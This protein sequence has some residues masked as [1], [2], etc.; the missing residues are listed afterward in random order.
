MVGVHLRCQREVAHKN[1]LGPFER[2][3]DDLS[4][5][6]DHTG[7]AMA[8][9]ALVFP[10]DV[11]RDDPAAGVHRSLPKILQA[12]IPPGDRYIGR[13]QVIEWIAQEPSPL[14]A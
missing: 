9:L 6:L 11:G 2:A 7:T 12:L 8:D 13:Q 5:R 4:V 14:T 1:V 10:D 3:P